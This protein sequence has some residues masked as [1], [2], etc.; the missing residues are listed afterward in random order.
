M[1]VTASHNKLK[2]ERTHNERSPLS[3]YFGRRAMSWMPGKSQPHAALVTLQ[4]GANSDTEEK[5]EDQWRFASRPGWLMQRFFEPVDDLL[6]VF[7]LA[8]VFL[9]LAHTMTGAGNRVKF[10]SVSLGREG[11]AEAW[12][13]L[14]RDLF[15]GG[16]VKKQERRQPSMHHE[17]GRHTPQLCFDVSC[18][19]SDAEERTRSGGQFRCAGVEGEVRGTVEGNDS[20]DRSI[21]GGN[22]SDIIHE[23]GP[24]GFAEQ[25]DAFGIELVL[26]SV[27]VN[28]AKPPR[29]SGWKIGGR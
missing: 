10:T 18:L 19:G 5:A 3:R 23:I 4:E 29:V 13:L 21:L 24:G 27:L 15:V 9:P 26:S 1:P 16:A 17:V 25:G 28:H 14:I 6:F 2:Q 20:G 12:R 22:H 8:C 11:L 7:K